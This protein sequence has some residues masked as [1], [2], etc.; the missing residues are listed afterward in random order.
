MKW[1]K[2]KII[3]LLYGNNNLV[4]GVELLIT[5]KLKGK[6]KN[7]WKTTSNDC[8]I[9]VCNDFNDNSN[10]DDKNDHNM[11]PTMIM[12]IAIV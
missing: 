7:I 1:P 10:N 5:Q 11:M 6:I 9:G 12:P 3:K 2:G 8:T 4:Q